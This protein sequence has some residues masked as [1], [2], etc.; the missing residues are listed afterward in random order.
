MDPVS[1]VFRAEYGRAVATL[2]RLLGDIDSAEEAVQEAFAVATD[3]WPNDGTPPN[4]GG[5]IVTTARN[6]ALDR[7]RRESTRRHRYE[8]AYRITDHD[9]EPREVGPVDD[10]RLR[11][12]FTCCHPALAPAAQ[13]ALTLRLLGGLSTDE[14]ARAFMV[15][16]PTMGQRISRAKAKI[17]AAGIPYRIPRDADLPD[18]LPPVLAVVYLIFNEGYTATTGQALI[19]DDLCHEAIR[20]ARLLVELMPDEPE[21]RGLL[22][23]LLLTAARRPARLDDRGRLVRLADQDRGRWDRPLIIEGH[24]IVRD[25]L[26]R[27]SPG[28]YQWQAAIAAVHADAADATQTDWGQIRALY[29]QL[30]AATGSPVVA[31]NRAVAVLETDGPAAAL[32]VLDELVMSP[33]VDQLDRYQHFH[34]TRAEVLAQ[35]DRPA[36]ARAAYDRALALTGNEAEARFLGERQAALP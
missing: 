28:P 21:A 15:P 24:A 19:R 9:P 3:R 6:R 33:A 32:Q 14:I 29:D 23:L 25:C 12:V 35:L 13:V 5:W 34:A 26:R 8:Q 16:E 22:A 36:D 31:V 2:T 27:N 30:L 10:D 7:I 4:P 18:R 20:L 17:T 1:T 11:L